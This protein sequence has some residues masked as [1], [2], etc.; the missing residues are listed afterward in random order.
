ME[1][2]YK[3]CHFYWLQRACNKENANFTWEEKATSSIQVSF[4]VFLLE[5]FISRQ[6]GFFHLQMLKHPNNL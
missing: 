5:E 1:K 2:Q 6:V 3:D 4:E